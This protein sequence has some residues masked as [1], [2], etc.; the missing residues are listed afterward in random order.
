MRPS[1]G[2]VRTVKFEDFAKCLGKTFEDILK[3]Q[4]K[5]IQLWFSFMHWLAMQNGKIMYMPRVS[6][7]FPKTKAVDEVGW[8]FVS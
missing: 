4:T 3:K 2:K 7:G 1:S 5:S 6:A 8:L